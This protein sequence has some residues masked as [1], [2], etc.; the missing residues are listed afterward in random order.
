[1]SNNNI[2]LN[3]K[4]PTPH[5][6]TIREAVKIANNLTNG[7]IT[8]GNIYRHALHGNI[9][10]S[11]Y[12]QSPIILRKINKLD[13]KIK[14]RPVDASLISR[15]CF[16]EKNCFLNG[17]SLIISTVGKYISP[18]QPVIDIPLLGY[19]YI[20]IQRL[21]ARSLKIPLPVTGLA[22]FN[23]GIT[24]NLHGEFFQIFDK[25]TWQQR[26]KQQIMQLPENIAS[27]I[28]NLIYSQNIR[29]YQDKEYF[30]VYDLPQDACFVLRYTELEKLINIPTKNKPLLST[31]TRISTPL[32]RLFWLACKHNEAISPLIRQPY[33][34]LSIFEQWASDD[35]ISDRLSGDTLKNALERGSPSSTSLSD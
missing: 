9:S 27:E 32:S 15:L 17:R 25:S 13:D 8:D 29:R 4:N 24:V 31:S 3:I 26:I 22:K 34:L 28:D 7:K 30:P 2:E 6:V 10:L 35:G 33:K 21:L 20:L 18:I 16:L 23:Y 11:I 19:H 14:L 5:W 12:F 1:M